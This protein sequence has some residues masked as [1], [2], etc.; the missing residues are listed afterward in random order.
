MSGFTSFAVRA[1]HEAS[2]ARYLEVSVAGPGTP[3][4]LAVAGGRG[5]RGSRCPKLIS[6]VPQATAVALRACGR[7]RREARVKSRV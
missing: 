4:D 3:E 7:W 5:T 1:R 6:G 2:G